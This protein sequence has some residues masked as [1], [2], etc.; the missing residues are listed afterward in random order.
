MLVAVGLEIVKVE[1]LG[2]EISVHKKFKS[3]SELKLSL[4]ETPSEEV[5]ELITEEIDPAFTTGLVESI[6]K[7][8]ETPI[9]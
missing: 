2:L 3:D 8:A 7:P 5:A 1:L 6:V 9:D 4:A